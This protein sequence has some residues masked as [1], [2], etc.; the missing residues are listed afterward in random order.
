MR[1]L[2]YTSKHKFYPKTKED[3]GPAYSE[4]SDILVDLFKYLSIPIDN[5]VLETY[6]NNEV[7]DSKLTNKAARYKVLQ[8]LVK[9]DKIGS[10]S[11]IMQNIISSTGK[12]KIKS[13]RIEMDLDRVFSGYKND[14]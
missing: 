8:S 5:E 13:G 11:K 12:S 14:S 1:A 7:G 4:L 6:V 9:S 2:Q 10:I 3:I